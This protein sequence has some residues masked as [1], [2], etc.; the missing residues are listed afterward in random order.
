VPTNRPALEVTASSAHR[1][2]GEVV[3]NA[4]PTT[5]RRKE[6]VQQHHP[7]R[8]LEL[9]SGQSGSEADDEIAANDPSIFSMTKLVAIDAIND[10]DS[11]LT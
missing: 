10:Y 7:R 5:T 6:K 4:G 2:D 1:E 9:P 3:E 8:Q 11:S